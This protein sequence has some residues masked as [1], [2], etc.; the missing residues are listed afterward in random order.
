M[1]AKREQEKPKG[2][3]VLIVDDDE[4]FRNLIMRTLAKL[5]I[6]AC[7]VERGCEALELIASSAPELLLLDQKLY[8][9]T[10]RT[11]VEKLSERG[12]HIPFIIM[13]GQG[14]ER[15]AVDMMKLGAQ[16]YL[17]KDTEFLDR[18]PGVLE[19]VFRAIQTEKKLAETEKEKEKLQAQLLQAQKMES[20][21]RLAGGVAHDFN[22]MLG[23]IL[24]YTELALHKVLPADPLFEYLEQIRKA[25]TRSADLTRQLL[26]FARKQTISPVTI[27]LNRTISEMLRMLYRLIGENVKL[28]F[29]PCREKL[30]IKIDPSQIDQILTNLCVNARDAISG[31]G[32]VTIETSL[33]HGNEEFC[34]HHEAAVAGS[35][36]VML[37]IRD[38]G[39]GMDEEAMAH[40]FEPFYTTKVIGRGTGL[41]LATIYGIVQQNDGFID[42]ESRPGS[43]STFR[44]YLPSHQELPETAG[45]ETTAAS[46]TSAAGIVLLVEDEP[47]VLAMTEMMLKHLGYKVY[48]AANHEEA[49]GKARQQAGQLDVLLT[50]VVM[51]GVNGRDL[52]RQIIEICPNIAVLYMSGYTADVISQQGM[53][54]QNIHF[55]QKP[56]DLPGLSVAIRETLKAR[57]NCCEKD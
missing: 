9:M 5:N 15:L 33:Q 42:V 26:A 25:A 49:I 40:L 10:G 19:R 51:P 34:L 44:L 11:I 14:D 53:V 56:F 28:V 57:K 18:I 4:G 27:D 2:I 50:D 24:G 23:A 47:T 13:T 7:G 41:G 35:S 16:D 43:G 12:L 38:N 45:K 22:N 48:S 21:G 1:K 54:S 6:A 8:D 29:N 52:A 30:F 55:I 46:A 17:V 32:Q 20:V 3:R 39:C 36:Y 37:T 31:T